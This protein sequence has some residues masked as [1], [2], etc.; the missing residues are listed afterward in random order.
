VQTET[1]KEAPPLL[2]APGSS[3]A[4]QWTPPIGHSRARQRRSWIHASRTYASNSTA[5][6]LTA[7]DM[8]GGLLRKKRG[9]RDRRDGARERGRWPWPAAAQGSPN[10]WKPDRP[11]TR[12]DP[13]SLTN[14][15]YIFFDTSKPIGFT[16]LPDGFLNCGNRFGGGLGNPA[17]ASDWRGRPATFHVRSCRV[18]RRVFRNV[19][20]ILR[21]NSSYV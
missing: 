13:L 17:A 2:Q 18:G 10:R 7:D 4:K 19:A 14:R 15:V 21:A 12:T 1:R 16:G 5:L 20:R 11:S 9:D 8:L 3:P 6:W